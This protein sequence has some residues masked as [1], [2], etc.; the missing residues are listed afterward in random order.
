MNK[1]QK[2]HPE[3]FDEKGR[4]KPEILRELI[5]YNPDTGEMRWKKRSVEWFAAK[6]DRWGGVISR[7][8]SAA[9]WNSQFASSPAGVV[10]NG[11]LKVA[12]FQKKY[13]GI[14][15]A[16]ALLNGFFSHGH[17]WTKDG[18]GTNCRADNIQS[19]KGA[20]IKS[21][22]ETRALSRLEKGQYIG[23]HFH[24][25]RREKQF[26]A[27]FNNTRLG[28]FETAEAAAIAYDLA[29]LKHLGPNAMINE[30]D[31]PEPKT[32][33][34]EPKREINFAQTTADDF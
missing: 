17:L 4:V 30:V 9:T 3:W 23:V 32:G 25:N 24:E 2:A 15:I 6:K 14:Q 19:R 29:A 1:Y 34:M 31:Q 13:T 28:W 5:D 26:D 33:P 10:T 12:I 7:A 21:A 20:I 27:V 16:F 22:R 18:D 8:A 11:Q